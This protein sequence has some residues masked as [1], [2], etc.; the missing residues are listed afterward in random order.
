MTTSPRWT[1]FWLAAA[2][3]VALVLLLARLGACPW[4]LLC[5]PVL[6][7]DVAQGRLDTALPAPQGEVMI[8]QSFTPRRDGL[9]SVELLLARYE[10]P[11]PDARFDVELLDH[12]NAIIAAE[13]LPVAALTNNQSYT[14]SF[15]PQRHSAG[16]RFVLRLRGSPG[17]PVSAWGYSLDVYGGGELSL[18]AG[19]PAAPPPTTAR[20][21]RFVTRYALTGGEALAAAVAPL[22]DDR[23]LLVTAAL[24]LPLPGVWLLLLFRPRRWGQAVAAGVA[25]ALGVAVWPLL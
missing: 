19:A 6:A 16:R 13:S 3:T 21:L 18:I 17:N 4:E 25:V 8:E 9:T 15:A 12:T 7:D 24:L 11:P 10:T 1:L 20:E 23:L 14:L 5:G 22:R 2:A